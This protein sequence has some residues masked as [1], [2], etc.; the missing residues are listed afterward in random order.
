M[1]PTITTPAILFPAIS[2]F[3]LSYTN[4]FL[5]IAKLAR[6]LNERYHQNK[7]RELYLQIINLRRR[8]KLIRNMQVSAVISF[9]FCIVSI[10]MILIKNQLGGE[11]AFGVSLFMILLSLAI[12]IYE[13]HISIV[14]LNIEL[15]EFRQSPRGHK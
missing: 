2:L 12:S 6:E 14:A 11:I 7:S 3:F 9:F 5:S 15:D 1:N 4:R 13:I 8:I 10:L